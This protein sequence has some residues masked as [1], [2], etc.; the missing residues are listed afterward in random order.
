MPNSSHETSREACEKN[1]C[2][3]RWKVLLERIPSPVKYFIHLPPLLFF[4]LY[5]MFLRVDVR[6]ARRVIF[7][8]ATGR[9]RRF[10]D[11]RELLM[12]CKAQGICRNFLLGILL[13]LQE[14]RG[15]Q[16]SPSATRVALAGGLTKRLSV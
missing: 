3:G 16:L 4:S 7:D 9:H 5:R 11:L 15:S 1:A 14:L 10:L 6:V 2:L 12:E 8:L 13:W